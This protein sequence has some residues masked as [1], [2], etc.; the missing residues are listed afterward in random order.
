M[1]DKKSGGGFDKLS[2]KFFFYLLA[3]IYFPLAFFMHYTYE[4][5]E[6]LLEDK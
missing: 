2:K 5:W 1:A 4:K 3:P 6:K